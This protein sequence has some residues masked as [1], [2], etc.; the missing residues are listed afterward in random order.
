M[1]NNLNCN[2]RFIL[3]YIYIYKPWIAREIKEAINKKKLAFKRK[4]K[5]KMISAQK[6]LKTITK[7][8]KDAYKNTLTQTCLRGYELDG[9]L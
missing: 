1:T 4:N 3:N 5:E 7:K 6:E 9:R 8:E 2:P